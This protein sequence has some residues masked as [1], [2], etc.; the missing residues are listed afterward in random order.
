MT[1]MS[2]M[3][4]RIDI[5]LRSMGWRCDTCGKLITSIEDGRVEWLAGQDE[6]GGTKLKG[7]RLV[8]RLAASSAWHEQHVCQYDPRYEFRN[9]QNVVEGLPLERFVGPDGVMLLLSFI[10]TGDMATNEVM[11]LAK[12]VQI[13]GYEQVRKL[14]PE[15]LAEGLVA[16]SIG[17]G[18][19][20]QW[21]IQSLLRRSGREMRSSEKRAV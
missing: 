18:Y 11:E 17:E 15:A 20:L 1:T 9:G 13:P 7:L 21:E 10:A 5:G 4:D 14:F 3:P 19:Y 12:R 16:P 8:H 6:Q 2:D